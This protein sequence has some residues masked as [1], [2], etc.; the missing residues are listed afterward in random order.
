MSA[1]QV[2]QMFDHVARTAADEGLSLDFDTVIAANTFDA[3]RLIHLAGAGEIP[4]WRRCSAPTSVR[5]P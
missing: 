3:H 5:E 1:E 2:R 4:W